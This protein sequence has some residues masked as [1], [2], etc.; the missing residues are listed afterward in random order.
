MTNTDVSGAAEAAGA[1][2]AAGRDLIGRLAYGSLAAQTLRAAVRLG[3][4]ELVGDA[5]R[6]A[7]DVAAEAGAEPQPMTR[8]LRA[9]AG[10]GLLSEQPPAPS[11]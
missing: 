1:A 6:P 10:L 5:P 2:D 8:L 11:R 7:A 3:V 4:M 9:L